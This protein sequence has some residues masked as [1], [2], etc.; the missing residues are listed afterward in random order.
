MKKEE[1]DQMRQALVTKY[2]AGFRAG[3]SGDRRAL[4]LDAVRRL[5]SSAYAKGYKAGE[6]A[7]TLAEHAGG[8]FADE[9]LE[10]LDEILDERG[11][12]KAKCD[13]ERIQGV[14]VLHPNGCPT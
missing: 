10:A 11:I 8:K 7:A 9:T 6:A 5:P 3:A 2:V 14:C 1:R 13:A 4:T 12:P